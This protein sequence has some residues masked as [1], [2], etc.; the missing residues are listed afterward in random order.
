MVWYFGEDNSGASP[1]LDASLKVP[2]LKPLPPS[3]EKQQATLACQAQ[4][5]V[6]SFHCLPQ[7]P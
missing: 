3:E 5:P 6:T 1:D 4:A 7:S 2:S